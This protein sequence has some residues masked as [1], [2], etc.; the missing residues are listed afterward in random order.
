MQ[1]R[2]FEGKRTKLTE[3][4]DSGEISEEVE[5]ILQSLKINSKDF[6]QR[7]A[8]ELLCFSTSSVSIVKPIQQRIPTMTHRY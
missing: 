5:K 7:T 2:A 6:Q 8:V 3:A 1:L 4:L